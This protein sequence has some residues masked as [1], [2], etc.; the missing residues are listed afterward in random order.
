M[1]EFFHHHLG[2]M[3]LLLQQVANQRRVVVQHCVGEEIL[4]KTLTLLRRRLFDFV[5][6]FQ[7]QSGED[8]KHDRIRIHSERLCQFRDML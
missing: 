8:V 2:D 1:E 4:Q 3:L 7:F 6:E 5:V